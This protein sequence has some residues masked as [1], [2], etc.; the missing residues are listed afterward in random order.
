MSMSFYGLTTQ[1]NTIYF[2]AHLEVNLA[3]SNAVQVLR[4]L[5]YAIEDGYFEADLDEFI[6]TTLVMTVI[7]T[8]QKEEIYLT[9]RIQH[10]HALAVELKARG[11]VQIYGA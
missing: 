4:T 10:L 9:E 5:G 3:N 8:E 1:G 7:P 2:P 6:G 11:A